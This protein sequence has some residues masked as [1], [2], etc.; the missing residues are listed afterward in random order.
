MNLFALTRNGSRRVLRIPLSAE[1][2]QEVGSM[3][4]N[5][6]TEFRKAAAEEIAFDGKYKPDDGESLCI[7]D[8]DDIDGLHAA[9]D[10]PMSVPEITPAASEF[11]DIKALWEL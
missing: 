1:I 8:Y 7:A 3:F 11:E 9:I 4:E 2:Q 6:E 5:Q 10:N